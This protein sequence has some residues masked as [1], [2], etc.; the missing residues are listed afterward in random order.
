MALWTAFEAQAATG[1][2]CAAPWDAHGVSIDTRTLQPGD[3]FI[4]LKDARDGHDFVADALAE[5]LGYE[6]D[7]YTLPYQAAIFWGSIFVA[8]IGLFYARKKELQRYG[9]IKDVG[10][11]TKKTRGCCFFALLQTNR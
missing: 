6:R 8:C 7:G 11:A 4:A 3:L 5:P 10:E 2:Y 1:G 9:M